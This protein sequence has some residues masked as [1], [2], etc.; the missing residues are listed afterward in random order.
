MR[1]LVLGTHA[2]A[3]MCGEWRPAGVPEFGNP[4]AWL[5]QVPCQTRTSSVG[6]GNPVLG[7]SLHLLR[8]WWLCRTQEAQVLFVQPKG[9]NN[10]PIS[11]G[12]STD[13]SCHRGHR[14]TKRLL[15]TWQRG[16]LPFFLPSSYCCNV[17]CSTNV[18]SG[19]EKFFPLS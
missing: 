19:Q 16:T 10:T 2:P 7:S 18:N 11:S 9:V 4:A 5:I 1:A 8:A 14:K 3:H 12:C 15:N 17:V 6:P 13:V